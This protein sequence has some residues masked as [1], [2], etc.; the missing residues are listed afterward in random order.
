MKIKWFLG[1]GK[2]ET[3]VPLDEDFTPRVV[4]Y[5]GAA[6]IVKGINKDGGVLYVTI[7]V[8]DKD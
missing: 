6:F 1:A 8:E 4:S 5:D 7:T 2:R 3:L